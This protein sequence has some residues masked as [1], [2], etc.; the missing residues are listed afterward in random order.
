MRALLNGRSLAIAAAEIAATEGEAAAVLTAVECFL[1]AFHRERRRRTAR[2]WPAGVAVG[3]QPSSGQRI[4]GAPAGVSPATSLGR[5]NRAATQRRSWSCSPSEFTVWGRPAGAPEAQ[6]FADQ[7]GAVVRLHRR[8]EA[9]I[10]AVDVTPLRA[11]V[12]RGS[13]DDQVKDHPAPG[14]SAR[15]LQRSRAR[16]TPRLAADRI[17][18]RD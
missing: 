6:I 18:K 11:A 7:G 2:R 3:L 16:K 4:R 10:K 9:S 14:H 13:V 1:D 5:A 8:S 12:D 15:L 17:R